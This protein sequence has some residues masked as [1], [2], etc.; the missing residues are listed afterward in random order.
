MVKPKRLSPFGK[1]III[2]GLTKSLSP[3]GCFNVSLFEIGSLVLEKT[4]LKFP[5]AISLFS[6][7]GKRCE[8]SYEQTQIPFTNGWFELSLVE[9]SIL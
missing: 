5:I 6:P 7:L 9:V 1:W 3:K 4:I 8:P 2:I